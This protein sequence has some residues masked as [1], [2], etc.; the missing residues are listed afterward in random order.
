MSSGPQKGSGVYNSL[1]N[2]GPQT[3]A[4]LGCTPNTTLRQDGV[5]SFRPYHA[6]NSHSPGTV[7]SG[8]VAVYYIKGKHSPKSVIRKWLDVNDIKE[9]PIPNRTIHRRISKHDEA[10]RES[11]YEILGPFE[12]R[13]DGEELG[14]AVKEGQQ[15]ECPLCG[16]N[17]TRGLAKHLP[18]DNDTE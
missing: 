13:A 12:T 9:Q 3:K 2:N 11:S 18:C 5:W 15:G 1:L 16:E 14:E 8:T 6:R 10:F 7:G 17:Y 4:E